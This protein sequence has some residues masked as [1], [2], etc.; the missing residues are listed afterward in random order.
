MGKCRMLKCPQ[1]AM[2]EYLVCWLIELTF[3]PPSLPHRA[4]SLHC[5]DSCIDLVCKSVVHQANIPLRHNTK[6][7][8]SSLTL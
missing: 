7:I 4:D 5:I 8:I 3:Q 1:T 2:P 6:C